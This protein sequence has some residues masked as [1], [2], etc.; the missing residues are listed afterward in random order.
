MRFRFIFPLVL[1]FFCVSAV[2]ACAA[3][4]NQT[5]G[6]PSDTV[7]HAAAVYYVAVSGSDENPGTQDSPWKTFAHAVA[8]VEP[9]DTVL[10]RGGTYFERLVPQTSGADGAPI[11]FS[12]YPGEKPVLSGESLSLG[13]DDTQNAI[14]VLQ[15]VGYIHIEGFSIQDYISYDE[16]MPSGVFVSG[17][18]CG[19]EITACSVSGIRTIYS[20]GD[21]VE[22]RNAHAIA[23]YG[24]DGDTAIDKIV[25]DG[26][27]VF[28]NTLGSS[29]AIALN[30]N[31]TNFSVTNNH[32]HDNDNIG[33]DF[34][35]FEG[36]APKNDRA[37]NG[38]C[39][40]NTIR[41]IS[42]ADNPAY[43]GA[44]GA[45]GIY[46]DGGKGIVIEGNRI[47]SCDI[48]IEAASEHFGRATEQIVIRNNVIA[49]CNAVAGIAFGGYDALRGRAE[50]I[51]IY[52]NTIFSSTPGILI[53]HHCQ[54]KTNEI[55][56]NI[57]CPDG[58]IAG[59]T[60]HIRISNNFSSDPDFTNADTGDFRLS[61]GS[62]AIDAGIVSEWCGGFDFALN[63]RVS[64]DAVDCGA[65]EFQQP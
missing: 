13:G 50:S 19:I 7:P 24:T 18:G 5:G 38:I 60:D 12:A 9:G 33:I 30:G 48:G 17:S 41:N 31:V 36:T 22:S 53:Q 2:C 43:G 14:V 1:A 44:A 15:N 51:K 3:P 4:E 16:R 57:L 40:G 65:L 47:E 8:I 45:G 59:G 61:S 26:C 56:N 25:I 64:G 20:A 6:I 52:N 63:T 55:C 32:V 10:V 35:G 27:E 62:A 39:S 11:V 21:A 46:V 28:E 29:E 58:T 54:Y 37:R 42:S 23:V 49:G 34:I